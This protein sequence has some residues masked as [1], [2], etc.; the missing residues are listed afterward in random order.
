MRNFESWMYGHR[1]DAIVLSAP[2]DEARQRELI[3]ALELYGYA[4]M[5]DSRVNAAL[6]E[7]MIDPVTL[8]TI[9][10]W[11]SPALIAIWSKAATSCPGF[12]AIVDDC[13]KRGMRLVLV[14]FDATPAPTPWSACVPISLK[15][16]TF[17]GY[18][19]IGLHEPMVRSSAAGTPA[20]PEPTAFSQVVR[21]LSSSPR[22]LLNHL[23]LSQAVKARL[24]SRP[25]GG[26][27]SLGVA[28]PKSCGPGESFVASFAAYT[29]D[30]RSEVRKQ[31]ENLSEPGDKIALGFGSGQSCRWKVGA[32]VSVSLSGDHLSVEPA[33]QR[34]EFN[35]QN[36][37]VSF[38]VRVD[39]EA[40]VTVILMMFRVEIADIPVAFVPLRLTIKQALQERGA[41]RVEMRVATSAFASYSSKDS[42][43]VLGRLSA[44][45]RW[46]PDLDIFTDCL[47]LIP[48]EAFKPMLQAE[49]V[50]RDLFLLFWSRNAA[51]SSWVRWELATALGTSDRY[52]RIMPMP[53]EDPSIAPL[54]P[55]FADLH[56]RDRYLVARYG[57]ERMR[58]QVRGNA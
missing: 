53:L 2:T 31:L 13:V 23:R 12:V 17:G 4:V 20:A 14:S 34:F 52:E 44:L 38:A 57:L 35:G 50:H 42:H 18:E 54:P 29:D 56:Q 9:G 5:W 28:A 58:E 37:W 25:S 26:G 15:G 49:I 3:A 33:T 45:S 46:Q 36:N 8:S 30:V 43:E 7:P 48:N 51:A 11:K 27:I 41:A 22:E 19:S 40:P 16:W 32:P 1:Y 6:A 21:E 55:E 39:R 10:L 24:D 47:D